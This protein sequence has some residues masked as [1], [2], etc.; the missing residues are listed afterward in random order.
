M[1]PERRDVALASQ[2]SS[3]GR[4]E[5]DAGSRHALLRKSREEHGRDT[6]R[7]AAEIRATARARVGGGGDHSAAR[8]ARSHPAHDPYPR[9]KRPSVDQHKT[10]TD[11]EGAKAVMR[12]TSRP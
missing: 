3:P 4:S 7:V 6:D 5:V 2:T 8:S 1:R 11:L 9:R 10:F 12:V